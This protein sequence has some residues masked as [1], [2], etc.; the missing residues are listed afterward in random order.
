MMA[1]KRLLRVVVWAVLTV[2]LACAYVVIVVVDEE[3]CGENGM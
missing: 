2:L 1:P 3:W